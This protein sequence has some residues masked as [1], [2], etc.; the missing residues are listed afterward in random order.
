MRKNVK[1]EYIIRQLA[2]PTKLR[3]DSKAGG[4]HMGIQKTYDS[5]RQK[6]FWPGM[7][8]DIHKYITKCK[9]CQVTKR[10]VHAKK[11]T[12]HPLPIQDAC[13]RWHMDILADLPKAKEGYQYI[14]LMIDSFSHWCECVFL[15]SQ[16]TAHVAKVL[17]NDLLSRY[18]LPSSILS[19]QGQNCMSK[20]AS[21]LNTLFEVTRIRTS[22]FHPQTYGICE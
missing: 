3:Y 18:G 5:I 19:D 16:D 13:S 11:H 6:Y 21:S 10:D 15:Q 7:Y 8:Q 20:L 17:Y 14:C 4:C 12:M 9:T 22:S 2:V 1:K